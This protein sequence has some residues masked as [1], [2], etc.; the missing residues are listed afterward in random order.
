MPGQHGGLRWGPDRVCPR[1]AGQRP[2]SRPDEPDETCAAP[3]D[4]PPGLALGLLAPTS[5]RAASLTPPPTASSASP[6]TRASSGPHDASLTTPI[7]V[8]ALT[9]DPASVVSSRSR[10]RWSRSGRHGLP[11]GFLPVSRAT[12]MPRASS[13]PRNR[14]HPGPGRPGPHV[15]WKGHK[16]PGRGRRRGPLE[17]HELP[18][19]GNQL[20]LLVIDSVFL[21]RHDHRCDRAGPHPLP[22]GRT[23]VGGG[24]L[25]V[26][27][28]SIMLDPLDRTLLLLTRHGYRANKEIKKFIKQTSSRT[29]RA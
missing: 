26:L 10:S 14:R 12:A 2:G 16:A 22:A 25:L 18:G 27:L 28:S 5:A 1:G 29:P 20:I 6:P 9:I 15:T 4:D 23:S 7:I 3:F 21:P 11:Q 24:H 8:A 17:G 19:F 13:P